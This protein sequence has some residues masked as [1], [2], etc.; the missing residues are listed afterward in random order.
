VGDESSVPRNAEN[1]SR[2][3]NIEDKHEKL[4]EHIGLVFS[5]GN[6]LEHLLKADIFF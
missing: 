1:E 3:E 2:D 4:G 6:F 5:L